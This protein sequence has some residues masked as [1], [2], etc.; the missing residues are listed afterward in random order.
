MS[1]NAVKIRSYKKKWYYCMIVAFPM[2]NGTLNGMHTVQ[3]P[4]KHHIM[5]YQRLTF[6]IPMDVEFPLSAM[7]L[8]S[9]MLLNC[10]EWGIQ[11]Y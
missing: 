6:K 10:N 9:T 2:S 11:S 7:P 4:F 8:T 1:Y 3:V 5:V